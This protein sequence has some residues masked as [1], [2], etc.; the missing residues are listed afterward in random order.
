MATGRNV[1]C[2]RKGGAAYD[3]PRSAPPG[4]P[5]TVARDHAESSKPDAFQPAIAAARRA[6]KSSPPYTLENVIGPAVLS[7][8]LS[9]V[10]TNST[11]PSV[12][13]NRNWQIAANGRNRLSNF[14]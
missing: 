14:T 9:S 12:Y 6:S 4:P 2:A 13:S 1:S 8:Q 11:E 10:P 3:A 5:N 7:F